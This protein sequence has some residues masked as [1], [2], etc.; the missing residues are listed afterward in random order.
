MAL[1]DIVRI[2]QTSELDRETKLGIINLISDSHDDSLIAD[3]EDVLVAWHQADERDVAAFSAQLQ[4]IEASF[5]KRKGETN[6]H[7]LSS[8]QRVEAEAKSLEDAAVLKQ[9]LIAE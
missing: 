8:Q 2:L 4:T 9:K 7:A 5:E 1:A 6:A 3:L